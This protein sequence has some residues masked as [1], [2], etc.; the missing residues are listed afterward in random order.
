MKKNY[1]YLP[2]R[3]GDTLSDKIAQHVLKNIDKNYVK[4]NWSDRGS[5]ERQYCAPNVDLPVAS[6]MRTKYGFYKEYHTSLDNLDKVVTEKGLEGGYEALRLA[7]E[8]IENN[9]YPE[10]NILC[11][12]QMGKEIY[13]QK[14]KKIS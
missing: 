4:F 6:I 5:D 7:I 9:F 12:P 1:S 10:I 13:F 8:A 14:Q 2:S 3:S 11:E